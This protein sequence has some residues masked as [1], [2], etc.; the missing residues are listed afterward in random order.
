MKNYLFLLGVVLFGLNS[1]VYAQPFTGCPSITVIGTPTSCYGGS[2]GSAQVVVL[3]ANPGYTINWSDP[4]ATQTAG[5]GNILEAGT[6]TVIVYDTLTGCSVTGAYVVNSPDPILINETISDALCKDS[7][8]GQISLSVTGGF[9]SYEY[10]FGT[11]YVT[12]NTATVGGGWY[13][14]TVEDANSCTE[15]ETYY[16][17]EPLSSIDIQYSTVDVGC[18]GDATGSIDVSMNNTGTPAYLYSWA[19]PGVSGVTTEDVSNLM[20]GIYTV[21]VTDANGCQATSSGIPIMEPAGALSAFIDPG[22][23]TD[24][25]CFG[26]SDGSIGVTVDEGTSPYSYVWSNTTTIFSENSPILSNVPSDVYTVVV[27]DSKGCSVSSS[28]SVGTPP[29]LLLNSDNV[30][31]VECY[32]ANTGGVTVN[33]VGG[34]GPGTYTY[35]WTNSSGATVGGNTNTISNLVADDYTVVI[36]DDNGCQVTE[37][38]SVTQSSS[39]V[40]ILVNSVT[41]VLCYGMNTGGVD[42]I[43]T[44]GTPGYTYNWVDGL[45]TTVSTNEDLTNQF[46]GNYTVTLTDI[47]G[48]DSTVSFTID[49]PT[50]TLIATNIITPV[51]CFGGT[52]GSIDLNTTGGTDPYTYAWTNSTYQLSSST[53]DLINYPSDTYYVT[54]SDVYNCQYIDSFV[55]DQPPLLTGSAVGVDILCKNDATGEIDLTMIGGT[56]L[57]TYAWTNSVGALVG[58]TEDLIN[59]VADTYSVIVTD[60]NGCQFSLS[61]TLTEPQDTLGFTHE[62]FPVICHGESNG[63]IEVSIFGGTPSYDIY[64]TTADTT[65]TITDLT[66]GWYE[67]I[68][69]DANG[70]Q[71]SDSVEVT[72]PALLL[73]NEV[74]TDVTC[75]GF[76]DGIID[77]TPTGGTGPYTYTWFNS[78]YTLSTQDQDLIDFPHDIYQLELRDSLSCFTEL[79]IE[80]PEPDPLV[81][82]AETV[83]V[84]CAGGTDGSIDV[85]VTGGNPDYTYNWT[86]GYTTQDLVNVPIDEYTLIVTDTKNCIDSITIIIY[87]PDSIFIDF[88]TT[89]V[90]CVDQFD[91]TALALPYGG[92]GDFIYEWA[93]EGE[94]T[95]MIDQLVGGWYSVTVTDIVGCIA[96]DSVEV[97][98]NPVACLIPPTAFTPNGDDYNDTWHLENIEIYPEINIKIFSR[99]GNLL[100]EQSEVYEEWN[101]IHN[102]QPLPSE[103]YY[104]I[105]YLNNEL[106]PLTGTITIVR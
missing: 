67:F 30:Q 21:T 19:G 49:Q 91:G 12:S 100:Y 62:S 16:V 70:C 6:Y 15:S 27:T 40:T 5:T 26:F 60:N 81:I 39:P 48:C 18:F 72:P 80:L 55:I 102:G 77:I 56:P 57:Y 104:Y 71:A 50:D 53:E 92:T 1:L 35:V 73:A 97:T 7:T 68:I 87:E 24:V 61:I 13:T 47:Y 9:G 85:T 45:G 29:E 93:N 42:I 101:G 22:A 4:S 94:I 17:D 79:F 10:D 99:W 58:T 89:E 64:W 59:I 37:T 90:S 38:Y 95:D 82:T 63:S 105:I 2:D 36:T 74:V 8:N 88:E 106:E 3:N 14:V 96:T 66:A 54:I 28:A 98:T 33:M 34:T 31:D 46:S 103:V 20:Q 75:F 44:G 65:A 52:D 41:H 84:T 69:T 11:G 86:N 43:A 51:S 83:D 76:S 23:I 32:G 78:D 25:N